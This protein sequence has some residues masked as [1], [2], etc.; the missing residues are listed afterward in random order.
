MNS[1]CL[2]IW[3]ASAA[4]SVTRDGS[5]S[6]LI[7]IIWH[8]VEDDAIF[9]QAIGNIYAATKI[10]ILRAVQR[11]G[12][13]F[14]LTQLNGYGLHCPALVVLHRFVPW[15]PRRSASASERGGPSGLIRR[16]V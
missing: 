3:P 13:L 2:N 16:D 6:D 1:L 4:E 9:A 15:L 7:L 8:H 12:Q 5:P 11:A 14:E 10:A